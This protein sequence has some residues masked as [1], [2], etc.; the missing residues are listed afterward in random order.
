M[1]LFMLLSC[2]DLFVDF[3]HNVSPQ[4]E[5]AHLWHIKESNANVGIWSFI[6][7]ATSKHWDEFQ[8]V[9]IPCTNLACMCCNVFF[10]K[11]LKMN[12]NQVCISQTIFLP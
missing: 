1:L 5:M 3:I 8:Y 2:F 10:Q 11:H 12:I 6:R 9:L 4:E 7:C